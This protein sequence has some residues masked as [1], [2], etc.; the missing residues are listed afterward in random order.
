MPRPSKRYN[1]GGVTLPEPLIKRIGKFIKERPELGYSST[2]EL[3]KEAVREKIEKHEEHD[4]TP[5][6]KDL[7][8]RSIRKE[9]EK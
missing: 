6:L 3:V 7:L 5:L 4:I 2:A 9:T 1:Y 8:D